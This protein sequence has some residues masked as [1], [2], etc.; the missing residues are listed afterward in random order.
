MA[1]RASGALVD[2]LALELGGAELGHDH[3]DL[4]ARRRDHGARLE[5]GDD[6]RVKLAVLRL[7]RRREAEKRAVLDVEGRVLR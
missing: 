7:E 1:A 5:P 6:A 3:V 2:G 4:M